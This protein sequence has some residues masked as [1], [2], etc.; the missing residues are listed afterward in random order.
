M[1]VKW[2]SGFVINAEIPTLKDGNAT[3]ADDSIL[4]LDN[5]STNLTPQLRLRSTRV[6]SPSASGIQEHNRAVDAVFLAW[7]TS[8]TQKL[9]LDS[10]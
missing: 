9:T 10:L 7:V 8:K 5:P 2:N 4:P 1:D 6:E 3:S